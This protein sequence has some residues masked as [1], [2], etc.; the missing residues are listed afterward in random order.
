MWTDIALIA[1]GRARRWVVAYWRCFP[2][3]FRAGR[4]RSALTIVPGLG[5]AVVEGRFEERCRP[6]ARSARRRRP[7]RPVACAAAFAGCSVGLNHGLID[8][9]RDDAGHVDTACSRWAWTAGWTRR[10]GAAPVRRPAAG[11]CR[12]GRRGRFVEPGRSRRRGRGRQLHAVA[13]TAPAPTPC[14]R[15]AAHDRAMRVSTSAR[16][17]WPARARRATANTCGAPT[18]YGFSGGGDLRQ[19]GHAV[20][21]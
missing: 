2:V 20:G 15:A 19:H 8:E 13:P 7:R 6:R 17:P 3:A 11:R 9:T 12:V 1:G 4:R 21:G 18:S 10:H 14:S 5:G 16:R